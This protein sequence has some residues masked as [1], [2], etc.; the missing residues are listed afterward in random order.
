MLNRGIR[1]DSIDLPPVNLLHGDLVFL[2]LGLC[3]QQHLLIL[4]HLSQMIPQIIDLL[5]V[6]THHCNLLLQFSTKL[7]F[8][9]LLDVLLLL[10]CDCFGLL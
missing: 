1:L 9:L 6:V 8:D 4:L 10:F 7:V 2:L 5:L 3:L